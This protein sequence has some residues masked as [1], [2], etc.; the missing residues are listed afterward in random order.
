MECELPHAYAAIHQ[1]LWVC[2]VIG[3]LGVEP[4]DQWCRR[5]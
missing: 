4:G 3:L 1:L 2:H 5:V